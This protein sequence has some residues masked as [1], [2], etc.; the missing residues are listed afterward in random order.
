VRGFEDKIQA[1]LR[2]S[3]MSLLDPSP[4]FLYARSRNS[5]ASVCFALTS[6]TVA[7]AEDAEIKSAIREK[8]IVVFVFTTIHPYFA[9]EKREF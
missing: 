8:I 3:R 1:I 5:Q 2:I 6:L 4:N 7:C 9:C